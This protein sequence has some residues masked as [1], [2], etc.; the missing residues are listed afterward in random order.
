[1]QIEQNNKVFT[2]LILVGKKFLPNEIVGVFQVTVSTLLL[3]VFV[4]GEQL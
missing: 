4:S 1:M 3:E 2:L